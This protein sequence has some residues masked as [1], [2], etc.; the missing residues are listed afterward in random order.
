VC[1]CT[2][3]CDAV[4]H[5]GT[6]S[7]LQFVVVCCGVLQCD[8]VCY[9]VPWGYRKSLLET[10]RK[11]PTVSCQGLFRSSLFMYME[12]FF[13]WM[14]RR[15]LQGLCN[16][17]LFIC[18]QVSFIGLCHL[19]AFYNAALRFCCGNCFISKGSLDWFEVDL[20]ARPASVRVCVCVCVCVFA[21]CVADRR[22]SLWMHGLPQISCGVAS[23]SRIIKI[24]S[25]FCKRAL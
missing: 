1:C 15:G 24:I 22:H 4:C 10:A 19:T 8:A 21:T 9:S 13:M 6:V 25:L 16:R 5:E 14:K 11:A 20:G 7:V 2:L 17:S 12:V 23:V 3:Q 18:V